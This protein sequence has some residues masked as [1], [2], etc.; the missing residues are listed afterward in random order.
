MAQI[1][2]ITT[3]KRRGRYNIF[4]EGQYAF[5][6]SEAVLTRYQLAKGL[7]LDAQLVQELQAADS[8]EQAYNKALDF[9][10]YQLRSVA[11]VRQHL[12]EQ[13]FAPETITQA[14]TRLQELGYLDDQAYAESFIRTAIKTTLDGPQ[15]IQRKL[16][17]KKVT[18]AVISSALK[19]YTE[20][21]QAENALKLAQKVVRQAHQRSSQQTRIKIQQRL[22]QVGY[23]RD[24]LPFIFDNL[25]WQKDANQ[26]QK[27]LQEKV[28]KLWRRYQKKDQGRQKLYATLLRQGFKSADIRQVLEDLA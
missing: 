10:S 27:L 23:S 12:Q 1:T 19:L 8:Q 18:P 20:E 24:L 11:E 17:S 16:Q 15:K 26:E 25:I 13:E 9:L 3:Q 6:V 2:K 21:L 14:I 5:A 28:Q 4:L 22:L 7:E